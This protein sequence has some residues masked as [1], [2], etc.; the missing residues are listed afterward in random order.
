MT[1]GFF[2]N[3]ER[4]A[5]Y[6]IERILHNGGEMLYHNYLAHKC[7]HFAAHEWTREQ[8]S[9]E[10]V[11]RFM[12]HD[13]GEAPDEQDLWDLEPEPVSASVDSWARGVIPK[14][15]KKR[16]MP[17]TPRSALT[18]ERKPSRGGGG[19]RSSLLQDGMI[20][21]DVTLRMSQPRAVPLRIVEEN[22]EEADVIREKKEYEERIRNLQQQ[23]LL[24]RKK[25]EALEAARRAQLQIEFQRDKHKQVTYDS[26]GNKILV[27]NVALERLP[28][29]N[30]VTHFSVNTKPR[31]NMTLTQD[32]EETSRPQK[33]SSGLPPLRR[34][35]EAKRLPVNPHYQK[36]ATQQPSMVEAMNMAP[37]V[38]L[39]EKGKSKKGESAEQIKKELKK[40]GQISRQDY[41][42]MFKDKEEGDNDEDDAYSGQSILID[43][44]NTRPSLDKAMNVQPVHQNEPAGIVSE[45]SMPAKAANVPQSGVS[46]SRLAPQSASASVQLQPAPPSTVK[47]GSPLEPAPPPTV[48]SSRNKAN[49]VGQRIGARD[50]LP[51]MGLRHPSS[52]R[53]M[54]PQSL[55]QL[56]GVP[57]GDAGGGR[58]VRGRSEALKVMQELTGWRQ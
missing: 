50:R 4:A 20:D 21:P 38:Q 51:N 46:G 45:V 1:D 2:N 10:L 43:L 25:K 56:S 11:L 30:P 18:K 47:Q 13:T 26:E 7:F 27:Q 33:R 35:S 12:R 9:T 39:H 32:I 3:A 48:H 29:A 34:I 5:E 6:V 16:S 54:R 53:S 42:A 8:L 55:P 44:D 23:Q 52:M 41:M 19:P 36:T 24:E 49:A 14:R 17:P 22:D 31:R 40:K 15:K 37:G 57:S 28:N 58:I